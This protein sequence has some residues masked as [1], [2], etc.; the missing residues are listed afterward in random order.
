MKCSHVGC[1]KEGTHHSQVDIG[2][3]MVADVWACD[4]HYK[5]V[6]KGLVEQL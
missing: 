1:P 5:E 4:D 3:G 6:M 2:G